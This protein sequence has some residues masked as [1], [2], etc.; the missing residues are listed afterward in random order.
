MV[1]I[2]DFTP[3]T[4]EDCA[5]KFQGVL[6]GGVYRTA[7]KFGRDKVAKFQRRGM[8]EDSAN[9]TEWRVWNELKDTEAGKY[10]CPILC[11]AGDG[12]VVVMPKMTVLEEFEDRLL[13]RQYKAKTDEQERQVWAEIDALNE[14]VRQFAHDV[15]R[16]CEQYGWRAN[17]LHERNIAEDRDGNLR[18]IDYGNFY[19]IA[20]G[21]RW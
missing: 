13:R 2:S 14:R 6:G 9:N 4:P 5:V 21:S 1:Y 11:R 20:E 16:A 8:I 17:D 3:T 10:L 19:R 18:V 12:T 15:R 7:Y